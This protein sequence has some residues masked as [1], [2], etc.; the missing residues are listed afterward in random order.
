LK[1]IYTAEVLS[2]GN[3]RNGHVRSVDGL[4]D[5]DMRTPSGLGG[6]GG[7]LNPELLFAAGYSACFHSALQAAARRARVE[8]GDSSVGARVHIGPNDAGTVVLAVELEVVIPN[9]PSELAQQLA[10]EAHRGCPYSLATR[11]NIDVTVSV[12]DD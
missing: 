12:T 3:A 7:G 10:D 11:G 6:P 9:L 4:L 1:P 5:A 2:T 8:L